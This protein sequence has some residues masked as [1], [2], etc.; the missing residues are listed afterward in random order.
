[1]T[2]YIAL[3]TAA[4]MVAA[5]QWV[6]AWASTGLSEQITVISGLFYL[7]YLEN[8]GAAFGILQ[9]HAFTLGLVSIVILAAI[10]LMILSKKISDRLQIW[11]LALI[12][13]GGVGNLIDRLRLGFV[14]DYLDFSALGGFPIFNLADIFVVIGTGMLM[15]HIIFI[16]GKKTQAKSSE[17]VSLPEI[18]APQGEAKEL[19]EGGQIGEN[20]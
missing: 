12:L 20:H 13:A 16:D 7:T 15:V 6:K 9:G 11:S 17:D 1:M 19:D 10:T 5:D 3:A 8:T 14:I 18:E 4:L 2:R